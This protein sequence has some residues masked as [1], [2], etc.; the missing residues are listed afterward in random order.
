[1]KHV[2]KGARAATPPVAEIAE[3]RLTQVCQAGPDLVQEP[4]AG[5]NLHQARPG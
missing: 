3:N 4:R 5:F 2:A 1:M